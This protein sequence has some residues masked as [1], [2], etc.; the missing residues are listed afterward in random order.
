[1]LQLVDVKKQFLGGTVVQKAVDGVSFD[2][3]A[4]EFVILS[5]RSGSGK[6]TLLNLIGGLDIPDHGKIIFE[7]RDI[8]TL[9]DDAV[10]IVRREKI[11]FIFQTFNL[12]PV[13]SAFENVEFPLTMLGVSK[14]E[15]HERVT[16][17]MKNVG[18][19]KHHSA[20]PGELSGGQRQRVA[21]ARAIVKKPTLILADE[22]TA[23]LDL[24][25]SSEVV[26][27][28]QSQFKQRGVSIIFCT[29]DE[30]LFTEGVRSIEMSDGRVIKDQSHS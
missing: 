10:S 23:N 27:L 9:S 13:L 3:G 12:V 1:M 26:A 20:K 6:T 15:R 29:H 30:S 28:I 5:G 11:G 25:T 2:L 24:Q 4:N 22:P 14:E 16:E 18:L 19:S 8:A 7:G 21:I 17:I